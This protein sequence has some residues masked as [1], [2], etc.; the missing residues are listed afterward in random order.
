MMIVHA[1]AEPVRFVLPA[2][3][4]EETVH[5]WEVVLDTNDPTGRSTACYDERSD[6]EAPGRTVLLLRGRASN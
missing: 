2:I 6:F 1:A 5:T 3:D 4:R